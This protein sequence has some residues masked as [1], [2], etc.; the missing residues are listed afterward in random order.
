MIILRGLYM[1]LGDV[2]ASPYRRGYPKTGPSSRRESG[3][4]YSI[5]M[6][7]GQRR[8]SQNL[9]SYRLQLLPCFYPPYSPRAGSKDTSEGGGG[10][11]GR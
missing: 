10:S 4:S 11:G 3:F 5:Y 6:G 9:C 7:A 2:E 1:W 8:E